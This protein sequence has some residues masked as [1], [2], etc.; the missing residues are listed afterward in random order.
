MIIKSSNFLEEHIEKVVLAIVGLVCIWLLITRVLISP[1]YVEHDN[2]KFSPGDIDVYISKQAEDLENELARKPEP[3]PPYKPSV[4]KFIA[5]LDSAIGDIDV[6]LWLSNPP[7]IL[8][9]LSRQAGVYSI[10]LI[11][12]INEVAV[13]HIRAA[14]YVPIEE[15]NAENLYSE[16][17]SEINDIDFVTVEAKFDVAGLYENFHES[18]AGWDVKEEWRDPCLAK[19]IFAAVQLQRQELLGDGGWS[20][21]QIVPRS[22]IE[23]RGKMLEVTEDVEELPPAGIKLLLIQFDER[24][25]RMDLLQPEAYRIVSAKEDWLPPTLHK[26]L[27]KLQQ[28]IDAQ[29]KREARRVENEERNREIEDALADRRSRMSERRAISGGG[30]G[31]EYDDMGGLFGG[32][33]SRQSPIRSRTDRARAARSG[34]G[35]YDEYDEYDESMLNR[36]RLTRSGGVSSEPTSISGIYDKLVKLLITG[37]TDLA[38]MREPLVF[39]AHDDTVEPKK[40]YRYRIRLGVFNP[41]AGTEQ[42]SEQDKW[43]KNKVI[44]WS[45]FSDVTEPVEIPGMMYFFP[46]AIQEA[47]NT[48]TVNVCR[49]VLGYWSSKDFAV[50]Q[51]EAIGKVIETEIFEEQEWGR[52]EEITT[53]EIIDYTTGAVLVD[54]IPVNDWLG[55]KYL[56]PRGYFDMLY[57]FDGTDIEH[58]PIKSRFWAT[59]L[60]VAFNEIKRSEREPKEPL[61]DWGSRPVERMQ[62]TTMEGSGWD[63]DEYEEFEDDLD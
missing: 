60:L 16:D 49:Y 55:T 54:V 5:K 15:I 9:D 38:K 48:V 50:K 63:E 25:L 17:V 51:G 33:S 44:L 40:G 23:H 34:R 26:E 28:D 42:F 1:N 52:T 11:G 18:F 59:E 14:A 53:L 10:P 32:A 61:R 8:R 3:P 19:P 12:E 45:K 6:G 7:H 29:E 47:T 35:E 36:G 43:Q 22:R 41:I 20:D 4:G 37:E 58:I 24:L 39:W 2:N 21:W 27:V 56:H 62:V 13:E 57:S 30:M 46:T 31:E